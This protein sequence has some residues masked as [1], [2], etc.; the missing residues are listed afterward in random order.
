MWANRT[1][2]ACA[3]VRRLLPLRL[4]EFAREKSP[5]LDCAPLV[6][7]CGGRHHHSHIGRSRSFLLQNSVPVSKSSV[8]KGELQ[9]EAA[10]AIKSFQRSDYLGTCLKQIAST[11]VGNRLE[12][13]I[14]G[15]KSN[16][17]PYYVS[18][19]PPCLATA[20]LDEISATIIT[21][22]PGPKRRDVFISFTGEMVTRCSR[23]DVEAGHFHSEF[24]LA[25]GSGPNN[26][27]P[28]PHLGLNCDAPHHD[29]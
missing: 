7:V 20:N 21:T 2:L 19:R 8:L 4:P 25:V 13:D 17:L 22:T 10:A 6:K 27:F 29:S 12:A 23:D 16:L 5:R 14:D 28:R 18:L 9:D 26:D 11:V 3:E 1:L 15:K 24:A